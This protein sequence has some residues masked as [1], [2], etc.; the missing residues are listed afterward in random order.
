MSKTVEH[1][2]AVRPDRRRVVVRRNEE[3]QRPGAPAE[4]REAGAL[5]N[6][7]NRFG[8]AFTPYNLPTPRRIVGANL[9]RT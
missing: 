3:S 4:T 5:P 7:L 2:S 8:K 9:F 1:G 6:D